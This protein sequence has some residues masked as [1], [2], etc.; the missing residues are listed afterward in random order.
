[1]IKGYCLA[2]ENDYCYGGSKQIMSVTTKSQ[3]RR[4]WQ[5][6]MTTLEL[7]ARSHYDGK[8][9][10]R[11]GGGGAAGALVGDRLLGALLE[12]SKDE[13]G[14]L[15]LTGEGSMLGELVK[16]VGQC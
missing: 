5:V 6:V 14:G 15:R 11:R 3:F 9:P 2:I 4:D 1:M 16:A 10:R 12:R 8:F 7:P 13:A